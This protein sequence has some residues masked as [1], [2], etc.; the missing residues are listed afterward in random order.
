MSAPD[1]QPRP[2]SGPPPADPAPPK[3]RILVIDDEEG[4][5]RG[6]R[7]V[8]V[9]MGFHLGEAADGNE[10]LAALHNEDWDVVL[11]DLKMP[12][13]V[14]GLDIVKAALEKDPDIVVVVIS[15]YATLEAAVQATRLG[16]Y[17]FMAKPFTPDELK[18]N[19]QK[20]MER[21]SL[22]LEKRRLEAEREAT[23]LE[24]SQERSRL[25]LVVQS[26]GD[27]LLVINHQGTV[28][29]SNPVA[30]PM[31]R[32][33]HDPVGEAFHGLLPLPRLVESVE[34]VLGSADT[35]TERITTE[36]DL[37]EKTTYM[38]KI[39]RMREGT[40]VLGVVL[41]LRDI[42]RLKELDRT[43]SRF[44]SVV[45]HE[46]KAPLAAVEGYLEVLLSGTVGALP[47]KATGM[48]ERCRDRAASLQNLIKDILN[49][50]RME[51]QTITR[52]M[53]P[54]NLAE[55]ASSILEL[56]KPNIDQKPVTVEHRAPENLPTVQ[57]DRDDVE[58]LL[59]NLLSNAVKYN[60][61]GGSVTVTYE[62]RKRDVTIHI[63]DTGIGIEKEHLESLGKEF[64]RVRN[65][66]T[67]RIS[68]TGLGLSI[69][70]KTMEF[71]GGDF[72][73]ESE[74]G[75]GST[76]SLTFPLE[77]KASAAGPAAL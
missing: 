76:F 58:R 47:D 3:G 34:S 22:V 13:G 39:S 72:H 53:E 25:N 41:V 29:F 71:Y 19:V 60:K 17:D 46:L 57:A 30:A 74:K 16:A 50:T 40:Q 4:I 32:I 56:L 27:A 14:D 45:S 73:I 24:L 52:R 18:M 63:A 5:R 59:T 75:V 1:Q 20:G 6:I 9:S 7:R 38:A 65:E 37:D 64:F 69:V 35:E 12:G 2:E 33:D 31:L 77:D 55:L 51:A 43:K 70:K 66:E 15:A 36:V 62:V 61:P 26:M 67:S 10:G 68:G 49:I 23:L 54:Q 11:T 28:V 21:R 42:S 48:L 44:V 8:L